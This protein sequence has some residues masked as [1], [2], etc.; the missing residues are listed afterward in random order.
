MWCVADLTDEYL[1]KMEDVLEV[2]ERPYN[3]AEPVVCVD[4]KPVSLHGDVRPARP[5]AP[6]KL[7]RPDNEY[8]RCGTANVF[9]AVEP[10]AGKHFT[11]ATPNRCAPQLAQALDTIIASYPHADTIHLVMDNLNIHGPKTLTG[12]FGKEK[13]TE[14]WNRL[15]V[16]YTPKH[17]SWLNQAE[18]EISLFA[19]QCLAGRRIP[20]LAILQR[21]VVAWNARANRDGTKINWQFT[22][23]KARQ[24]FG[25]TR[26]KRNQFKRS[27]T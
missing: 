13:G 12:Y 26:S 11:L 25:Y 14:L 6:G 15:T 17:G 2:Y 20:S 8:K 16:H 18:I 19:R 23:K 7:R 9:C 22:R 1:E 24:K 10:K 3:P 21:E 27:K 4:E 5:M